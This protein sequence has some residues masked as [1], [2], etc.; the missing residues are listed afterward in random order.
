[1]IG[2]FKVEVMEKS[3]D[4]NKRDFSSNSTKPPGELI[5][6]YS[7]GIEAGVGTF[8]LLSVQKRL[9]QGEEI[10]FIHPYGDET[11]RAF[12]TL[13][14]AVGVLINEIIGETNA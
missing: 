7:V 8:N 12:S 5:L 11:R 2:S 9:F 10:F 4:T 6:E 13:G 14:E 3:K 1:M